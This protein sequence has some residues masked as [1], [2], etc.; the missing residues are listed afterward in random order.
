[1]P[2]LTKKPLRQKAVYW[3]RVGYDENGD[4][5][6]TDDPLE[7]KVRW[8][9]GLLAGINEF[10]EPIAVTAVVDVDR[11]IPVKSILWLGSIDDIPTTGPTEGLVIVVGHVDIPNIKARQ[12]QR[13]VTVQRWRD[14]LPLTE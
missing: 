7:I 3:E 5:I 8:E 14:R 11:E 13:S 12:H 10:G 6:V 2:H 1:M 4:P 9:E